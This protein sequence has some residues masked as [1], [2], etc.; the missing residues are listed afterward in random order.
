MVAYRDPFVGI[1]EHEIA[2][3]IFTQPGLA[4]SEDHIGKDAQILIHVFAFLQFEPYRSTP[5]RSRIA[6]VSNA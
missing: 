3:D 4:T 6:I 1:Y 5:T 2:L